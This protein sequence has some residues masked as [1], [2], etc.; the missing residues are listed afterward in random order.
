MPQSKLP[1]YRPRTRAASPR[2]WFSMAE[3][4]YDLN[5]LKMIVFELRSGLPN[6][7]PTLSDT[8]LLRFFLANGHDHEMVAQ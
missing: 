5:D 7:A 2:D 3:E 6:G 8:M 4:C 1:Y